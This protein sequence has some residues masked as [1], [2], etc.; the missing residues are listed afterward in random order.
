MLHILAFAENIGYSEVLWLKVVMM[1]N[2]S[3]QWRRRDG[4]IIDLCHLLGIKTFH[5]WFSTPDRFVSKLVSDWKG[6]TYMRQLITISLVHL[7]IITTCSGKPTCAAPRLLKAS[8]LLPLERFHCWWRLIILVLSGQFVKRFLSPCLSPSGDRLDTSG[9]P[10]DK[11]LVVVAF[12]L[13]AVCS[14]WRCWL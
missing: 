6:N 7:K 3:V 9:F 5:S 10:T 4:D 1:M 2:K 8:Q 12:F 13:L 11:P 14:Y